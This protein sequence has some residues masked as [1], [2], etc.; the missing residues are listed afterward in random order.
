MKT[1]RELEV[2]L[3]PYKTETKITCNLD[4][5]FLKHVLA[6]SII[7]LNYKLKYR[8]LFGT[9]E[10]NCKDYNSHTLPRLTFKQRGNSYSGLNAISDV[11]YNTYAENG[12]LINQLY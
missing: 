9:L 11:N 6:E 8:I 1:F 10:Q 5:A 12:I 2:E 4:H 3:F 7:P